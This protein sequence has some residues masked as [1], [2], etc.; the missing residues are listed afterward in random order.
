MPLLPA[1]P[2]CTK[3]CHSV[4][5][6]GMNPL[7]AARDSSVNVRI[8]V[9]VCCAAQVVELK[10]LQND[11]GWCGAVL[12]CRQPH[13]CNPSQ[14][15]NKI[16]SRNIPFKLEMPRSWCLSENP[17]DTA[18]RRRTSRCLYPKKLIM[19]GMIR[20]QSYA[21][22]RVSVVARGCLCLIGRRRAKWR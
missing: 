22:D 4:H 5:S 20:L 2:F 6:A 21:C 16:A 8:T 12:T 17:G 10:T 3:F 7:W 15:K 13:P 11:R 9:M 1:V 19:N 14:A 18:W